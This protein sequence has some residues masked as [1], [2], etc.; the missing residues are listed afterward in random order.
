MRFNNMI[1]DWS[2][3]NIKTKKT[4][5]VENVRLMVF[6]TFQ[7][8]LSLLFIY[9]SEGQN[10]QK[11]GTWWLPHLPAKNPLYSIYSSPFL[12]F[13]RSKLHPHDFHRLGTSDSKHT[14]AGILLNFMFL[15]RVFVL[16]MLGFYIDMPCNFCRLSFLKCLRSEMISQSYETHKFY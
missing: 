2:S 1:W 4:N 11:Y 14:F 13:H 15:C 16:V 6:F 9:I 10:G 7:P 5:I 8:K 3:H 12:P